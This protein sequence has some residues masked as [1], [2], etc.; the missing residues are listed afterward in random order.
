MNRGGNVSTQIA[1]P[2]KKN[3]F[4]QSLYDEGGVG[5]G[6][7]SGADHPS[8]E[9]G[10]SDI[11][12]SLENSVEYWTDFSKVHYHHKS[13]FELYGLLADAQEVD[14]YGSAKDAYSGDREEDINERL[15]FFVEECDHIQVNDFLYA[16]DISVTS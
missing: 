5:D 6:T 3:L 7:D 13:L 12:G 16:R 8:Q 4:L 10:D 15:R 1:K 11:I 2:R 9:T 14:H